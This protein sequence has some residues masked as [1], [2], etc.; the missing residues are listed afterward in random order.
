MTSDPSPARDPL[1]SKLKSSFKALMAL[2]Y[3]AAGANHFANPAIY[4]RIMPP[5]LPFPLPLVYLSG[6]FEIGLGLLL[7]APRFTKLAAWGLIA[8]LLAVFPANIQM[9]LHPD[10]TPGI[11]HTLLWA[12]LP[13]QGIFILAAYWFTQDPLTTGIRAKREAP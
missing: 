1:R 10:L 7:L 12:R 5:Y 2:F 13:L 3:I 9:A 8:L 4:L 11:P 6:V